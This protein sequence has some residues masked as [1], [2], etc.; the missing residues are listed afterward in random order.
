MNPSNRL[1][2][3]LTLV[4][5]VLS[6]SGVVRAATAIAPNTDSS[7]P[8]WWWRDAGLT[9]GW[10]FSLSSPILIER[11]G[12]SDYNLDGFNHQ[13]KVTLW[14]ASSNAL[15]SITFQPG[16][17]ASLDGLYRYLPASLTLAVGNYIIG[18]QLTDLPAG[19]DPGATADWFPNGVSF[20]T[21]ESV[22]F[23]GERFN[24]VQTTSGFPEELDPSFSGSFQP[25]FQYTVI[26]EPSCMAL[27]A[28]AVVAVIWHREQPS[29]R[30]VESRTKHCT[31]RR[32]DDGIPGWRRLA[33]RE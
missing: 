11:I 8:G 12:L 28:A 18:E 29:N 33:R 14:G 2:L 3:T 24:N 13:H 15:A 16:N 6:W 31:R 7:S 20:T 9:S 4:A 23:V 22:T 1:Q 5:Y 21:G 25:N 32:D 26:P 10:E 27:L 19:T 30:R 17:S